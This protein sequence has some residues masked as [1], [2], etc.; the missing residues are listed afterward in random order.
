MTLIE[1]ISFQLVRAAMAQQT[2]GA[3]F[4]FKRFSQHNSKLTCVMLS[5]LRCVGLFLRARFGGTSLLLCIV[6]ALAQDCGVNPAL[7][8]GR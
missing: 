6:Y 3:A 8:N 2:A 7:L 4:S 1:A 5:L